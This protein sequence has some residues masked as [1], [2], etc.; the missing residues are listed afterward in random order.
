MPWTAAQQSPQSST[1]SWSLLKFMSIESVIIPNHLIFC[2]PLLLLSA[3]FLSIRIFS[4]ELALHIR[5]PNWSFSFSISRSNEYS[6][7][8]SFRK[9]DWLVCSPCSPRDS[10]QCSPAPPFKSIYSW[11]FS[12][13]YGLTLTSVHDYWKNQSF[14]CMDFCQQSDISAF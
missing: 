8:I 13:L 10:Q 5:W 9:L 14:D 1:I 11:A 6:G 4:N 12:L 2:S 7:L 3:I